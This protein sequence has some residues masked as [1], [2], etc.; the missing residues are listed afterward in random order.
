[1]HPVLFKIPLPAWSLPLGPTL[2]ALA[3]LG[4]L[5]AVFAQRKRALDMLVIGVLALVSGLVGGFLFRGQRFAL[6]SLPIYSYGAMLC[7]SVVVGWFLTLELGARRGLPRE[8]LANC[9]F[10]TAIAA[11]LGARILYVLTNLHEFRDLWDVLAVRRGGLVAYGG[12]LGG[13]LGSFY[14]L[15]RRGVA[16]LPWADVAVPS[17]ASGLLLTRIGCYLFGCD[18]GKPLSAAAPGWLKRLGTF[19]RWPSDVLDGAGSPAWLQHVDT[20]GLSVSS[21]TSLPVH[22]TELYESL[23]GGLLLL[24][25]WRLGKA[26]RFTGES[27]FAFTFGY[28]YLRFWLELWRDDNERG[29]FGPALP[30]QLLVPALLLIFALSFAFG[31]AQ[32]I[33]RLWLRR[34]AI[35]FGLLLVAG[36]HLLLR[37]PPSVPSNVVALSTSQWISLLTALLAAFAWHQ[38]ARAPEKPREFQPRPL[39]ST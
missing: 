19:P 4:F 2:F 15:R 26:R 39:S 3:A 20:R 21:L 1:M 13:F 37:P 9:Y 5:L 30:E 11:L 27:F 8:L 23:A 28:G 35:A 33:A 10:V 22:P 34:L 38:R 31:P 25:L 36:A 24:L 6:E 7:L 17:L 18:F 16:L 32:S 29:N 14:Y 12:F